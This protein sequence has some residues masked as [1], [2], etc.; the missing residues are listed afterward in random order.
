MDNNNAPDNFNASSSD[1]VFEIIQE[2]NLKIP[3]SVIKKEVIIDSS[4]THAEFRVYAVVAG[5]CGG[6]GVC[7]ARNQNL[8]NDVKD[9]MNERNFLN[10]I[11]SLMDKGLL[12]KKQISQKTGGSKSIYVIRCHWEKYLDFLKKRGWYKEAACVE[13]YFTG[14]E[15]DY[16]KKKYAYESNAKRKNRTVGS[17][18]PVSELSVADTPKDSNTILHKRNNEKKEDSPNP[19]VVSVAQEERKDPQRDSIVNGLKSTNFNQTQKELGMKYFDINREVIVKG[20]NPLGYVISMIQRGIAKEVVDKHE[21]KTNSEAKNAK[22]LSSDKEKALKLQE[23]YAGTYWDGRLKVN[24]TNMILFY[25]TKKN[26]N[27]EMQTVGMSQ[28]LNFQSKEF[29]S[30]LSGFKNFMD[31]GLKQMESNE[32]I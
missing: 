1:P 11:K 8:Y 5:Y 19:V 30:T 28:S 27:G 31:N 20:T 26:V 29:E 2:E 9:L 14:F 24:E 7:N 12:Y 25:N 3:K 32:N 21:E 22:D 18:H 17:R 10:H 4:I 6:I 16:L 13:S 23:S 15:V